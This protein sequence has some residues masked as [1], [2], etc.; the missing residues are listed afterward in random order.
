MPSL[1]PPL[2]KNNYYINIVIG[3]MGS[4]THMEGTGNATRHNGNVGSFLFYP[5]FKCATV[6]PSP[7]SVC[8]PLSKRLTWGLLTN[9]CRTDWRSLPVPL[10]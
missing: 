10:P 2:C 7:P 4:G 1:K 8:P 6:T 3:H 5:D 9:A